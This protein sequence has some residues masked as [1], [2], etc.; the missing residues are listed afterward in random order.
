M[1]K[2]EKRGLEL[3]SPTY[4]AYC[5][6]GG[7]LS[8]GI[9]HTLVTPLDLSK[10]RKQVGISSS[11]SQII[12]KEGF[13][14]IYLGWGPTSIGYSLQGACKFG[15]YEVFKHTYS[16]MAGPA[17][18][19]RYRDALWLAASATAEIIADVFLCPLEAVKV[20]IQTSDPAQIPRKFP[21]TLREGLPRILTSEGLSG[22]YK[23]IVPLWGRQVPY[24][25]M[26]FW[27]FERTVEALYAYIVPKPRNECTNLE[28]LAVTASSGYIAGVFC[29]VV[30]HPAD[31]I[32]SKL[33]Q[34]ETSPG[35][36]NIMRE[37]GPM[38]IWRGLGMRTFMIGT[39]TCLQWFI[40]DSF[41]VAMGFPSTGGGP[42]VSSA[43]EK[44]TPKSSR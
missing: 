42:A 43:D 6:L 15:F 7:V 20:R 19:V 39:L 44:V 40:Y 13:K 30:S 35:M 32:I 18:A 24:T 17:N 10:C 22:L 16:E 8:C 3:Y 1:S 38:G 5:V 27:G 26:K 28:Q 11:F 41:K 12:S 36:C 37:L 25:M 34:Y 23:G 33:N 31:S 21:S 4:Y 29:A 9:T 2:K 14:S